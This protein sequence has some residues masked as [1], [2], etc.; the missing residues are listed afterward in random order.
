M[1]A[2]KTQRLRGTIPTQQAVAKA[3]GV[4]SA[5]VSKWESGLT[6]PR[7][8]LLPAIAKLYGCTIDELFSDDSIEN[9]EVSK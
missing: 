9:A 1:N 6:K 4:R 3:L 8:S 5:A 2:M 7:A